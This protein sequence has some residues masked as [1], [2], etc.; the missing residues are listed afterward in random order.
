[1]DKTVETTKPNVGLFSIQAPLLPFCQ[2][3]L[4]QGCQSVFFLL[5]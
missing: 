3:S 4:F 1:M 5:P 2:L